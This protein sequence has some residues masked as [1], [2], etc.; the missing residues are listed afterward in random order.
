MGTMIPSS[1]LSFV[2]EAHAIR[3]TE[4][5][6][7]EMCILKTLSFRSVHH[8]VGIPIA[9]IGSEV[10]RFEIFLGGDSTRSNRDPEFSWNMAKR[11]S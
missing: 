1:D 4:R 6:R 8:I 9:P 3:N 2:S 10:L 11:L 5:L 7:R